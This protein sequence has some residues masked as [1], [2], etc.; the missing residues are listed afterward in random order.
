MAVVAGLHEV[1]L[2]EIEFLEPMQAAILSNRRRTAPFGLSGGGD[3][4]RGRNYVVRADG[5]VEELGHTATTALAPGDRFVVETP[6]G[7]GYGAPQPR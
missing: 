3:G 1:G 7:G 4:A 5:R 2:R 6:G